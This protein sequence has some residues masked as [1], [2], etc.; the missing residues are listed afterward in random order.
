MFRNIA[1][2]SAGSLALCGAAL[3]ATAAAPGTPQAQAW[4]IGPIVQGRNYSV[5][6]PRHPMQS[7]SS[8]AIDLPGPTERDG[9]VH[10]VTFNPGSLE[11]ARRIVMRYRIDMDAGTRIVPRENP[12]QA[13]ML[14]LHFQR[15]GDN[16]S[17]RGEY[18]A[19]RW[20]SPPAKMMPLTRGTHT[21]TVSL[22]ENWKAVG[23]SYAKNNPRA[24]QAALRNTGAVGFT[25]GSRGGRGHGVYATGPARMTVLD[26]R[27]E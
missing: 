13:A 25:L 20:Y 27:V 9:H 5:G 17:G 3:P 24:F 11:G 4:T 8:I 21:V 16:W 22:D 7:G 10:Y 19:Y 15:R 14:S 23:R 12:R 2:A 26:F 6:M 18:E 1:I